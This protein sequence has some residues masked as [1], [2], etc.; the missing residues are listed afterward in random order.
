MMA[1]SPS[2]AYIMAQS[3]SFPELNLP[4]KPPTFT[5]SGEPAVFYSAVEIE[6]LVAPFNFL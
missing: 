1:A 5:D 3:N 2:Y 6:T 4:V